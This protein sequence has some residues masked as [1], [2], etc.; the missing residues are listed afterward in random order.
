LSEKH[1]ELMMVMVV[2]KMMI[3]DDWTGHKTSGEPG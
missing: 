1:D 2:M 3:N